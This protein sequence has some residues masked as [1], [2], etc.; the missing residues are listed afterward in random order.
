MFKNMF[1]N[2]VKCIRTKKGRNLEICLNVNFRI[3]NNFDFIV[4]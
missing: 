1:Y 4:I 2:I 3:N